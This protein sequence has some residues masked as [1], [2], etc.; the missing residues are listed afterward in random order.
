MAAIAASSLFSFFYGCLPGAQA[1]GGKAADDTK[2]PEAAIVLKGRNQ[3][4]SLRVNARISK[5]TNEP[6]GKTH[7]AAGLRFLCTGLRF[8]CTGC[9]IEK[10]FYP[11]SPACGIIICILYISPGGEFFR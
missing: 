3:T 11:S 10:D 1:T 7:K 5:N 6:V 8:L 4:R 9:F 2:Y